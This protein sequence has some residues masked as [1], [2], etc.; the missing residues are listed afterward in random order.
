MS[1]TKKVNPGLKR[2]LST[3]NPLLS[4]MAG[5]TN[6]AVTQNGAK[7]LASS[8]SKTVD[9]FA[10]GAS[11]R[12]ADEASVL[13]LFTAAFSED[14][15]TALKTAFYVR[16]VRNGQGERKT[17]L[18]IL[19]YLGN[20]YPDIA[21]LN[22]ENI[23]K[24]G[25][26]DDLYAFE[27]TP[28]ENDVFALFSKQL[29]A[30]IISLT[31]RESVSLLAKWLKSVNTSSAES[32][33][34]GYKTAKALGLGVKEYRKALAKLRAYIDVIEVKL[35]GK[36]FGEIDYEKVPSRASLQYRKAFNK[37]DGDR[38]RAYLG[39]VEKGEAKINA[40]TLYPYDI[41]RPI[42]IGRETDVTSLKTL[43]LQWK[44]Q[45]N[46]LEGNEHKGLVICDTSGSMHGEPILVALSLAIY[47]AERNVGPF[48]D[49]FITFSNNPRLQTIPGVTIAEKVR[50]L[51][52]GG[53]GM[54]TDL[55]SAFDLMLT[56]AITNRVKQ[57]D[58]V[59][60]LYVISDMAFNAATGSNT[61]TNFEVIKRK[62]E[63]AGYKMPKLV[64]WNVNAK[65]GKDSPVKFDENGTALVSGCSP[66]ILK[67]VLSA[68]TFTPIDIM[69]ET[70]NN[71]RYNCIRV[72]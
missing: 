69:L 47:F 40:S 60:V 51:N 59:D 42:E 54:S 18:R 37:Q 41:I 58:M 68:K 49:N 17:F 32:R 30:D 64:F 5:A 70:L 31:K 20:N 63:A 65:Y 55:Q 25:R 6:V 36:R 53:W 43:D 21:R 61:L 45:P 16:D 29:Q 22:L 52:R 24:F 35:A 12:A 19:K 11:L 27:G 2:K 48:K 1:T 50:G 56:T 66:S 14:R 46:W 15:L 8:L 13:S 7:S 23:A 67:S 10:K 38:Y 34:L 71:E 39:K 62:Y 72:K 57:A 26:W 33:R 28:V 4:G 3:V 9:F 44:N